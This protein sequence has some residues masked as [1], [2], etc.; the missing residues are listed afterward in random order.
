MSK[1]PFVSIR[2]SKTEL[3]EQFARIGKALSSGLRIEILDLLAQ[4]E[5][6]VEVLAQM[7]GQSTQNISQHLQVL[8]QTK[9]I[10]GRREGNF[11]MYRIANDDV[12]AL[13]ASVQ[14]LA[15]NH[16]SEVDE[17]LERFASHHEEFEALDAEELL[18]RARAGSVLVYDVRP[19]KEFNTGHL[20]GAINVPLSQLEDAIKASPPGV[21][22][23]AYCRGKYCLMAY[24]AVDYL[25]SI[26]IQAQRLNVGFSEWRLSHHPITTEKDDQVA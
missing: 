26:G 25:N 10:T 2:S 13:V 1:I 4:A 19:P 5:L 12:T 22:I 15:H 24:A 8:R 21:D 9:L 16:L 14:E 3:F 18:K 7:L 17:I 23:V 11:M 6:S 20:P